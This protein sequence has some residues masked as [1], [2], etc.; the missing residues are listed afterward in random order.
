[1]E[2]GSAEPLRANVRWTLDVAAGIDRE[3]EFSD[4]EEVL[5][6]VRSWLA[7]VVAG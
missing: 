4:L 5:V 6:E 1:M 3:V 2:V 7:S